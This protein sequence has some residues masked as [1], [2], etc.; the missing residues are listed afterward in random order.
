[1]PRW[2]GDSSR[3]EEIS[4]SRVVKVD[5]SRV[6]GEDISSSGTSM[7]NSS[8][9]S[10][11]GIPNSRVPRGFYY[12]RED[13]YSSSTRVPREDYSSSRVVGRTSPAAAEVPE[14]VPTETECRPDL[15]P[16][17]T[18]VKGGLAS[19]VEMSKM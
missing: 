13:Y 7:V 18:P 12:S 6:Y 8:R 1:M 3:G 4:S 17:C 9:V 11:W 14:R 5:C 10:R 15:D 2:R 19:T 16:K